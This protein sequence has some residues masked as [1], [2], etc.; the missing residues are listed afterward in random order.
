MKIAQAGSLESNDCLIMVKPNNEIVIEID[1]IV[2]ETFGEE[3]K[4]TCLEVLKEENIKCYVH[5]K[6]QG[7]YD[8]VIK[9]RLKTALRRSHN[10]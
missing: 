6:D 7:A 10:E 4:S 2:F 9:A 3:I 8:Y 5:V 1:S